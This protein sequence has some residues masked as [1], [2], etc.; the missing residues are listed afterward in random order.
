[1]FHVAQDEILGA[2]VALTSLQFFRWFVFIG[3]FFFF[4]R[5]L[6]NITVHGPEFSREHFIPGIDN[7]RENALS[8]CFYCSFYF[9]VLFIV[10]VKLHMTTS[11][12]MNLKHFT[13]WL[14]KYQTDFYS[15]QENRRVLFFVCADCHILIMQK[16]FL[17]NTKSNKFRNHKFI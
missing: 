12:W 17:E 3:R 10:E 9:L 4:L 8:S 11:I 16:W 13:I 7:A 5:F 1:L 15:D 6:S 14:E 2:W